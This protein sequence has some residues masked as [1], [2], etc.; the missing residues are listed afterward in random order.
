MAIIYGLK[1][2]L[3]VALVA[4]LNH[5]AIKEAG[6][7]H[8]HGGGSNASS[9]ESCAPTNSSG[10]TPMQ[11]RPLLMTFT[12]LFQSLISIQKGQIT[13]NEFSSEI[14]QVV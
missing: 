4:M 9:V 11:V 8:G 10:S 2:N 5:T 3:S 12:K 7:G 1:V 14:N 6:G 13:A